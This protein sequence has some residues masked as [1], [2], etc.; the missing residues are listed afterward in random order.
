[1]TSKQKKK[2]NP[3]AKESEQKKEETWYH[4]PHYI[5]GIVAIVCGAVFSFGYGV[6]DIK[7]EIHHHS[8]I[9]DRRRLKISKTI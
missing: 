6:S 4:N 3:I 7:S 9:I 1:M 5:L 8:V 2:E